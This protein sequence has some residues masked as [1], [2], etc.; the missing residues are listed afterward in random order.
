MNFIR[1]ENRN[2][3]VLLPECADDY[4]DENSSVRVVEA[5]INSLDLEGLGFSRT[6]PKDTGRPPYDPKDLLKLYVYGYMNRIRSSRRLEAEAKRNLEAIWLLQKLAPDHKTIATFRRENAAALKNVFRNFVK[7]CMKLGLYG[8]E[9]VAV[10]GSKFRA[11][12]AKDRNFT[13][14]KLKERM[15][16]IDENI[17]K[18]M[19][20]LEETDAQESVAAPEKTREEIE[21]IIKDLQERKE[22]Y[23]SYADELAST[24]ETQI[25]LTDPDSRLMKGNGKMDVSYNVQSVVDSKH[26]LITEFEV[27]NNAV[28]VNLM[29]PMVEKAKE[30]LEVETITAVADNGYDSVQDILAGMSQGIEVHVAGTDFDVCVAAGEDE[31]QEITSHKDG[32]CVYLADRNVVLCPMGEILYPG[33]YKKSKGQAIFHNSRACKRCTCKCTKDKHG[34]RR[35][36]VPM[37]ASAFSKVY[38][39]T[40]LFAKQIR[41]VGDKGVVKKRKCIVEHPFGTIKRNMDAGYCLMKGIP[42][43]RGEFSLTFLAY[44]LKRAINILGAKQL[45]DCLA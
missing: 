38:D 4:V 31:G 5:Y 40:G 18:Y 7:L 30:I 26:N 35:H 33:S 32:R 19:R 28:D 16:R 43:V 21:N 9:L 13:G 41:I 45:M 2:Q 29:T 11:A 6:Q 20:E 17:E 42:K 34:V 25:S 3:I 10:D 23:Q 37:T 1:G 24:G 44:N 27:T 12:N 36:E 22:G 39:D 14:K 8:K 15:A